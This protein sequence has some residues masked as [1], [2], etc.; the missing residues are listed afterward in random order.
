[1]ATRMANTK[2]PIAPTP[3]RMRGPIV[4]TTC[5][6]IHSSALAQRDSKLEHVTIHGAQRLGTLYGITSDKTGLARAPGP[7]LGERP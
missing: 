2:R 7:Y 1:M 3:L 5:A 6:R 4:N